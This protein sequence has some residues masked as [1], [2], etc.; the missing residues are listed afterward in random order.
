MIISVLGYGVVGK[1]VYEMLQ[2]CPEH[3]VSSVLVR[4]GKAEQNKKW[5]VDS[6]DSILSDPSSV[7]IECMGG[8]EPAF[9]YTSRCLDAGKSVITSN[10][11]LVAAHGIE[12]MQKALSKNLSFLFSAACGGA[13]PILQNIYI[14][15]QTDSI[16]NAGGILNGTTNYMLD[17]M[18]SRALSFE[19]ALSEA[20]ALGY[21]E[22]DPTADLS[23]L[24]TLR[25]IMLI[26]MVAYDTLPVAGY[27]IEGIQNVSA[28]DFSFAKSINCTIRLVGKTG[29]DKDGRLY[30]YVE[31][32]M[33]NRLSSLAGVS[34]NN[35]LAFY[36]GKNCGYMTFG[37]QGA[38]RYPTASA[39]LRDVF[40]VSSCQKQ[41]LS[42]SCKVGQ[43]FNDSKECEHSYVVRC[44]IGAKDAICALLP[45][46][47]LIVEKEDNQYW[48]V[49]NIGVKKMHESVAILREKGLNVFF[50]ACEDG[51]VESP[52][53]V[54]L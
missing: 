16:L 15:R 52:K 14:A 41:M 29:L 22:A 51:V 49:R 40:S 8:I 19:D 26:S 45:G 17:C 18:D 12:L 38:G 13:I 24:D 39:V 53:E 32:V 3:V 36:T 54:K 6:I 7:V 35:N 20:Q 47:E 42:P 25:K 48:G 4:K 28:L 1:G 46:C 10:K 37:G 43:V 21:A 33:Y 9:E 27:N 50:A 2:A 23:G 11:A 34:V 5:M 30:A 31:P 44:S